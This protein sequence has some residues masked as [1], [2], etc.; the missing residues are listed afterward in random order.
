M[1]KTFMVVEN[2][3]KN[4]FLKAIECSNKT[5]YPDYLSMSGKGFIAETY[6]KIWKSYFTYG[7]PGFPIGMV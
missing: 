7:V 2:H 6:Q 1:M 4:Y 5:M 3:M